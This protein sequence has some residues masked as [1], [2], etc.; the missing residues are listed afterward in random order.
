MSRSASRSV[1]GDAYFS[2]GESINSFTS[3]ETSITSEQTQTHSRHSVEMLEVRNDYQPEAR[4]IRSPVAPDKMIVTESKKQ[5]NLRGMNPPPALKPNLPTRVSP[6]PS[7]PD[8]KQANKSSVRFDSSSRITSKRP[9]VL[10]NPSDFE[11]TTTTSY[12]V[13][14]NYRNRTGHQSQSISSTHRSTLPTYSTTATTTKQYSGADYSTP[15]SQQGSGSFSVPSKG[16]T[17]TGQSTGRPLPPSP[18]PPSGN[19]YSAGGTSQQSNNKGATRISPSESTNYLPVGGRSS[20]PLTNMS[21]WNAAGDANKVHIPQA[22]NNGMEKSV[23]FQGVTETNWTSAGSLTPGYSNPV[24][25]NYIAG[26]YRTQTVTTTTT[27][28]VQSSNQR[29]VTNS[30]VPHSMGN[31]NTRPVTGNNQHFQSTGRLSPNSSNHSIQ[32]TTPNT[33]IDRPP[34][35]SPSSINKPQSSSAVTSG[36]FVS[37]H[38]LAKGNQTSEGTLKYDTR[39]GGEFRPAVSTVTAGRISPAAR[40]PSPVGGSSTQVAPVPVIWNLS[41]NKTVS[42]KPSESPLPSMSS[43]SSS[44]QITNTGRTSPVPKGTSSVPPETYSNLIATQGQYSTGEGTTYRPSASPIPIGVHGDS[45]SPKNS[46]EQRST[47][48]HI[49]RSPVPH[50]PTSPVSKN[51]FATG[52]S[53]TSKDSFGLHSA[54]SP[55]SNYQINENISKGQHPPP[56]SPGGGRSSP[57]PPATTSQVSGD[58]INVCGRRFVKP[59]Q[60]TAAVSYSTSS[61]ESPAGLSRQP[62]NSTPTVTSNPLT[63]TTHVSRQFPT[64]IEGRYSNGE[65]QSDHPKWFDAARKL[66]TVVPAARMPKTPP[67]LL[68]NSPENQNWV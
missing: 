38:P 33:T 10:V 15:L 49:S 12:S 60:S 5:I 64:P 36:K 63:G 16:D 39:G 46:N 22:V 68:V 61:F 20:P 55:T 51:W 41:E 26:G 7:S 34:P 31:D 21:G 62:F 2:G 23:G 4:K 17:P 11:S 35:T 24:N 18:I 28:A 40:D 58:S 43:Y 37:T 47:T 65:F 45:S 19:G 59:H 13:D 8:V 53:S 30:T 6:V 54:A 50:Y 32:T 25:G 9:P 1:S 14:N 52:G 67:S 48:Y 42:F 57:R 3:E 27:P 56:R 29:V 66:F 44:V